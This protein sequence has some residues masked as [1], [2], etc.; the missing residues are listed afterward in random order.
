MPHREAAWTLLE[1]RL[2]EAANF[3]GQVRESAP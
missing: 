2:R 3:C 1:E